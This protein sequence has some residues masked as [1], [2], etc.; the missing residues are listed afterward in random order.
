MRRTFIIIFFLLHITLYSQ[1]SNFIN[2]GSFEEKYDCNTPYSSNKAKYWSNIGDD[3]TKA[4]GE[5]LSFC[6]GLVPKSDVGYQMPKD[7]SSYVRI[8]FLCTQPCNILYSR[9]Y[10]KNRLKQNLGL[11]KTYCVKMYIVRQEKCPY[12]VS[13]FG[14]YFGNEITD[15]IKLANAPITYLN[16][17]VKNPSSNIISD[18]LN[19]TPITGTFVADGT[20]KYMIIGN[21][22]SNAATTYSLVDTTFGNGVWAEYFID[23]ISCIEVNLPAYAGPDKSITP[24]DSVY[25]GRESDFA[26]DPGCIWYKLPNK[27]TAIDTTS[28]IWVKPTSTSTYVVKQVL[29]CSPEKWDTVV[30]FMDLVG[31]DKLK[32]ISEELKV[33]PVP[34]NNEV[35][36]NIQNVELI[37]EFH[38]LTIYNSLGIVIREEEIRFE[39]GV[40][41]INTSNL[42]SGVYFLELKNNSNE[43]VNKKFLVD[44]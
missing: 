5:L 42:P 10:L 13:N 27:T 11:G 19:W 14:F 36:L 6:S 43:I 44:H 8:G 20:E 7:D 31:L 3:S 40:L 41:K 17:Q 4:A 23:A 38:R 29:E 30:V 34:A 39:N 9:S 15:T 24:G 35:Q 1:I 12:A 21:F 16:P 25:I 2:N 18:T 22:D 32:I 26:I 33:F 37:K 28:G